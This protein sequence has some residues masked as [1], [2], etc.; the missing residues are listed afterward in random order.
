MA[1]I[2]QRQQSI[3][4]RIDR[5]LVADQK[6]IAERIGLIFLREASAINE[7]GD[8]AIPPTRAKVAE[9]DKLVWRLVLKPYFIGA[10]DEPLDGPRPNSPYTDR[11]MDGITEAVEFEAKQQVKIT[12]QVLR[13]KDPEL[14]AFLI[15][16]TDFQEDVSFQLTAG[17]G[18]TTSDFRDASGKID[19]EAARKAFVKP[20]GTYDP[21][22]LFVDSG[23]Y[24][25]SDRVWRS[26]LGERTAIDRYMRYHISRGTSAVEM[27]ETLKHFLTGSAA[28]TKTPK[29]YGTNG[30]YAARRLARTEITAAAGRATIAMSEANPMVGGV[31]WVLSGSH[32]DVDQC[33]FN[34]RGGP[35]GDGVYPPSDVP[36][37]PDHPHEMCTLSPQPAGN[38]DDVV[39]DIRGRVRKARNQ[40]TFDVTGEKEPSKT[41]AKLKKMLDPQSLAKAVLDGTL[42]ETISDIAGKVLKPK[43]AEAR[44]AAKAKEAAKAQKLAEQK[45]KLEAKKK[46]LAK[47]KAEE[48]AALKAQLKG[49]LIDLYDQAAVLKGT[50][51]TASTIAIVQ[52]E[53][54]SLQTYM[55]SKGLKPLPQHLVLPTPEAKAKI[56]AFAKAESEKI[57]KAL[58][59]QKEK[60][61]LAKI[62]AEE[63]AAKAAEAAAKA[64][65]TAKKA[66]AAEAAKKNIPKWQA[67][68]DQI[69][70]DLSTAKSFGDKKK[71]ASLSSSKSRFRRLIRE[72]GGDLTVAPVDVPVVPD[73]PVAPKVTVKPGA[74][75]YLSNGFPD[76]LGR[77]EEMQKLGGSTGATLVRDPKDGALYVRK[78]GGDA[79]HVREEM[80]TDQAYRAMGVNVP[81]AH[82]YE[83]GRRPTKLARYI[84]GTS[85]QDLRRNDLK[86]Y[87]K[88]VKALQGDFASDALL[89]NWDVIG[90]DFDNIIVQKDG[91]VWRI[92]NGGGLRRRAQGDLKKDLPFEW[93][94]YTDDLWS[95]R[96][97]QINAQDFEVFGSIDY[98]DI[99]KQMRRLQKHKKAIVAAMPDAEMRK[100]MAA[101]IATM[102]DLADISKTFRTDDWNSSYVDTFSQHS[103]GF[104]KKGI[105][106]QLPE[107][108]KKS[109][110]NVVVDQDGNKWDNLRYNR[111]VSSRGSIIHDVQTY[112]ANNG[113][114]YSFVSFWA[115][116]QAGDSWSR[117]PQAVKYFFAQQRG[118]DIDKKFWWKY[119]SDKSKGIFERT[120][121]TLGEEKYR[122][123][124]TQWHAFNY[125]FMRK[126]KFRNNNLAKG[127][128]KLMRTED[129]GVMQQ[130]S[131]RPGESGKMTRGVAESTSIF[132][133]VEVHGS[134]L[135]TQHVPHHRILGNYFFE[136]NP[137]YG[138]GMFLGDGENEFIAMMDGLT[139]KYGK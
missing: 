83:T 27:A 111:N 102:E 124:F 107:E 17:P 33:D 41:V 110:G 3:W 94:E 48:E 91:T 26:G 117:G 65:E 82:L 61:L 130:Q 36:R 106:D 68:L 114:D 86:A 15:D 72:A 35:N 56:D 44:A 25:L 136:R 69:E 120:M 137:N 40:F 13:S 81:D 119:G 39:K 2:Q 76:D 71:V 22:H 123:T 134:E 126:T 96:N 30:S 28:A 8:R 66:L 97:Q 89:G 5:Q 1:T 73:R 10:G 50:G 67:K 113:G 70:A 18:F 131:F 79:G 138:A 93:N 115:E 100:L 21:A 38:I 46:A 43:L 52:K 103:V 7:A 74:P 47:K 122:Q 63:A 11:L 118:G 19:P 64:A 59:L 112:M 49:D 85:L 20:R 75:G 95:M 139:V 101:R 133:K 135:T 87:K 4:K 45:A 116:N 32:R 54:E 55:K 29:P 108:L 127:T 78:Q 14:A 9:L 58:K 125:E 16:G 12:R 99:E 51:G 60:E 6:N 121:A 90:Q 105:I 80:A 57:A 37:Y 62:Q 98:F 128:V 42:N 104:R 132:R 77:L 109:R 34:A 92:D 84:E 24:R 23:G 53:I 129:W 31:R 88:A